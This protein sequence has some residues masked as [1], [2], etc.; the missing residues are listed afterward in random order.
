M[1]ATQMSRTFANDEAVGA[2]NRL[3][4]TLRESRRTGVASNAIG[5][6]KDLSIANS[7]GAGGFQS[8]IAHLGSRADQPEA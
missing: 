3:A 8:P 6:N 2:S 5:A 4:T 7:T 1:W